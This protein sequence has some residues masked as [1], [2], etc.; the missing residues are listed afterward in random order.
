GFF[1]RLKLYLFGF[2]IGALIVNFVFKGRACRLPGTIKLEEL[3]GQ[4]REYT[5]HVQCIIACKNMDTAAVSLILKQGKIN[6]DKSNVHDTP[7]A[8]YAVD[9]FTKN[10]QQVQL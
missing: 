7:C 4:K 5:L 2:L 9:G 6:Y 10:K 1:R 3:R 8:T